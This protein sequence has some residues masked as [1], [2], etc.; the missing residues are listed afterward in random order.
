MGERNFRIRGKLDDAV[1]SLDVSEIRIGTA[2][3]LVPGRA[4]DGVTDELEVAA[5]EVVRIEL[6]NGFVL[7]SRADDLL[8]EHGRRGLSRDGGAAWEFDTLM[9][10]HGGASRSERGLL[11]LGIKVL[12]FFGVELDKKAARQL[13]RWFEDKQ[14]K[15]G[16]PALYHCSLDDSF[17]LTPL[18]ADSPLPADQ[19]PLLIF[20]HGTASSCEGSFGKLWAPDNGA[21]LAARRRLQGQYAGRVF[22]FEHRSLSE[23]PIANALA[24]AEQLPAGAELHLVSHSRGG[25]IGEL[26]CLSGCE[27]L[28]QVLTP[29]RLKELFA[30]DRTIA[31]Q[32][33]LSPL[34]LEDRQA[35]DDAYEKDRDALA[36]L[37]ET[38]VAKR[39][40]VTRFVRAACPARGTTLASG[41]LDRWLSVLDFLAGKML[42][43]NLFADGLDFLLAVV[44]ERTD[45]RT[46]PGL[47]AMMPG[48]AL[49]RLLHHPELVTRAD[50]SVIAGD[51]E[52]NSLWQKLK[53][54]ASDW[55]YGADHDLVVNTGSMSGG[56]RRPDKGA[57]F[58][59]DKGSEVNHFSYFR[60]E[61]SLSWLLA[62]L[63]RQDGED[64]G[65][66]PITA[67]QH[68]PPRWREAVDRT[69]SGT[70]PRP[71][72]I[73]IPGFMGSQLKASGKPI[74]LNYGALLRGGLQEL[75][76]GA[77]EITPDTLIHS[78]YGPLLEFLA[79][80]HRVRPFAYDWRLS[81]RDAAR[82]LARQ[83]EQWLPEAERDKQPVHFVAHSTGGLVVRAMMADGG[84]GAALWQRI[85]QLPHSRLLMLG[86][87]NFGTYEAVRWLTGFNPTL[88]KLSL[89]DFTHSTSDI[90]NMVRQY[91]GLLELLPFALEDPDFADPALWKSLQS[92]LQ[93]GRESPEP[94]A[95]T[96]ARDTWRLLRM[97]KPDPALMRYVAGCQ[98]STIRA[99]QF[100]AADSLKPT[101][102]K[103]LDFL[104]TEKGDGVVTWASGSLPGV[105]MWYV[106][107]TA[108]D[109][110][111]VQKRAFSAYLDLLQ[112]E[113][114]TTTR[115]PASPP[116]RRRAAA[117][118]PAGFVLPASPPTDGIPSETALGSLG[119]GDSLPDE[120]HD[121]RPAMPM[122]EISIRHGDL[123][124]ARHP[125]MVGHYYGDTILSAERT[126]DQQ[127]DEALSQRLELG[128]YPGRL[129]THALFFNQ[130]PNAK[131]AGAIVVGLGQVGDLTPS[132]LEAGIR[133]A[134]LDYALQVAQC[135]DDR[136][137]PSGSPRHARV[138]CLL[139]GTGPGGITVRDSLE[140][141]LRAAI[142]TNARLDDADL[143]DRVILDRLEFLEVYED[144][145][146]AAA[147]GL[148]QILSVGEFAATV[149]WPAR[150]VESGRAGRRRVRFDDPLDW[151][152][153]VE[154]IEEEGR[155]DT[156]RFIFATDR[157]RAE[158]TLATGQ[159]ALAESF[160]Q[161]ASR[162]AQ[163][164]P[165]AA[166]TLHE[167]LL[168]LRLRESAP[169]QTDLVLLVDT[170][171][172]RYPWEMLE[173][174]WS[175]SERPAAVRAGLI[176]Q[177]KT[178]EFRPRPAHAFEPHALVV[179]SPD[180]DGWDKFDDLP[181]ARQEA[182]RVA[183]LLADYDWQVHECIDGKADEIIANLHRDA[184]RILHLAGHGAHEYPLPLPLANGKEKQA[185]KPVSGMVIARETF[186]T[187]GDI[188]QMRWV[189]ELVF[190]NCCHLGRTQSSGASDRSELAA[191]L[192]VQF[193]RMG[194]RA[195]VAAGWAVDDGAANAFAEAFY[196]R[197]LDGQTF[198]EA[199]RAAR[200]EIWLRFRGVN[201]WGAYQCYGDPSYRLHHN[202]ELRIRR[203]PPYSTPTELIVDLDNLA[204]ELK[205]SSAASKDETAGKRINDLLERIPEPQ[206]ESW[207]QRADVASALGFA[208]GEA[209][210]WP[211]AIE[212]LAKAL[213]APQGNCPIRVIEQLANFHVRHAME[214]WLALQRQG[215]SKSDDTHRICNNTMDAIINLE[216]LC[217][218]APTAERFN[219]LGSAYK[220]L[221]LMQELTPAR[222]NTLDKMAAAYEQ[223][224]KLGGSGEAYSFSN[225]GIAKV[226]ALRLDAARSDDWR[227]TLEGECTRLRS[228][229]QDNNECNPTFWNSTGSADLDLVRLLVRSTPAAETLPTSCE[230]LVEQIIKDYCSAFKRGASPREQASVIENL[231]WLIAFLADSA[232]PLAKVVGRIRE[233]I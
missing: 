157:A 209:R 207:K 124:Y 145:A 210:F 171:S 6:D 98:P 10:G 220:R 229:L 120:S 197:L 34:D 78:L 152:H 84:L 140:T 204:E 90:V 28:A 4:R 27:S 121:E 63:T 232:G 125:V 62:G 179:G 137:G 101:G 23:S 114:G 35:R 49:T 70:T 230:A 123:S 31:E 149:H 64:G 131:P 32:L 143:E 65:F 72:A 108:H 99:Y 160:I 169:S 86:T 113:N 185:M 153:R 214:E 39:L 24:L 193:I 224:F 202:G 37:I 100:S 156:L 38:L 51:I 26:L 142:A 85:V 180:L 164:N 225:W 111:C 118:E 212:W 29:A 79:L 75:A 226:L 215:D 172:A 163:A 66:L 40:R 194:V 203:P 102:Y 103:H 33:G 188:E 181:G 53:L 166:R 178:L 205:A 190:I 231:D 141:I 122:I 191:N 19:G 30:A 132:L 36:T 71:L 74:W 16:P 17:A 89:L 22:A 48:S 127:L 56:L 15:F 46:L 55:F 69:L 168:P 170:C 151:W 177:L 11:G 8:R 146:I 130:H 82:E 14:F 223:S 92:N 195:V 136:F 105:P 182:Q 116:A 42:G 129:D 133:A 91:P 196:T 73:V 186:L 216:A 199:V 87:P 138:S 109:A 119:F 104:A 50:L 3:R 18:A 139:V 159:L 76:I 147:E 58:R 117:D 200:E 41:R 228:K 97:A 211:E 187:P 61:R 227:L 233:A 13:G 155:R 192:G 43:E 134:L 173:N 162:S 106:E 107:D 88:A 128:L 57:R 67:A 81:L 176:R 218:H 201:T 161:Q 60:N 1:P 95:L 110:L 175:G 112:S 189:P 68:A 7:W 77:A 154:I 183:K 158:E 184:W 206:R 198:G 221:A 135:S 93:D 20:L 94:T 80:T 47:E 5:G 12:D 213:N 148:R 9:P 59:E 150:E 52:G 2:R 44:K 25:L 144:V 165:E 54:L 96:R 208:W 115:L 222:L 217:L 126:L 219:L 167:M 21:G 83:L 174:R 45:P